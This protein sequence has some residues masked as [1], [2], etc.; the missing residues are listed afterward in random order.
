MTFDPEMNDNM[1]VY[2]ALEH[3]VIAVCM[4]LCR[5][6]VAVVCVCVA[7]VDVRHLRLYRRQTV[8]AQGTWQTCCSVV[9]L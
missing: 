5:P 1:P 4:I 7:V 2:A 8:S 6:F 9:W 3:C